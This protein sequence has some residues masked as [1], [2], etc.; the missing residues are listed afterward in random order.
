MVVLVAD[1]L[2]DNAWVCGK[3][4]TSN[5]DDI[6]AALRQHVVLTVLSVGIGFLVAALLTLV[7]RQWRPARTPVLAL[8]SILYTI[9]SLALF[10][11]LVP[12]TGLTAATVEVGLVLYSLVI[13]VRNMLAGLDGVPDDVKEVAYGMGYTR[14]RVLLRVEL[15]M[16]LP[17]VMSGLRVATVSTIALATVGGVIDQGGLGNLIEDAIR[18]D[19]RAEVLTA[20][21][22][23]VALALVA[24][25][26]L[27]GLQRLLTPWR[28]AGR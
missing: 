6:L 8:T 10:A 14:S 4:L 27:L 9:P 1:C 21:V 24:D 22:L 28:R 26:I 7:V 11:I 5:Q 15:P 2:I 20:S 18:R 25:V 12:I 19:F 3:Y 13:L 16:A 23:V 17:A